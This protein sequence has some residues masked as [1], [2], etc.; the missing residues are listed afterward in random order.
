MEEMKKK[1]E[2]TLKDNQELLSEK[3]QILRQAN[4][5]KEKALEVSFCYVYQLCAWHH[6]R[7]LAKER[8]QL[9]H[10]CSDLQHTV[11]NIQQVRR[12]LETFSCTYVDMVKKDM[13]LALKENEKLR[14]D[15]DATTHQVN[16]LPLALYNQS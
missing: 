8:E 2:E 7:Q 16:F 3:A 9:Y 15:L 5:A 12:S 13:E 6:C 11:S 14:D 10:Q 1:T 4:D